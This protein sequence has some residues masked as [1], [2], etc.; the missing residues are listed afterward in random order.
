MATCELG[1][2]DKAADLA[3]DAQADEFGKHAVAVRCVRSDEPVV[4]HGGTGERAED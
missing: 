1:R 4:V 2:R 3:M